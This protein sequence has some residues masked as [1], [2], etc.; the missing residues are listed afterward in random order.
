MSLAVATHAVAK[1]RDNVTAIGISRQNA[2]AT[3]FMFHRQS[4]LLLLGSIRVW[5]KEIS[6]LI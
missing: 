6:M 4:Q 3:G 2:M 1:S 5:N